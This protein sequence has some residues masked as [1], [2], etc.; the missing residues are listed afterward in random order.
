LRAEPSL[1]VDVFGLA[2]LF[3]P[4]LRGPA[5]FAG[6]GVFARVFSRSPA[7]LF[8]FPRPP[9]EFFAVAFVA[10]FFLLPASID[11]GLRSLIVFFTVPE[12]ARQT[13]ASR[14]GFSRDFVDACGRIVLL[15]NLRCGMVTAGL[16]GVQLC[17]KLSRID[18]F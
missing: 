1:F 8:I 2:E 3:V 4:A 13:A 6:A 15:P 12:D 7:A 16:A 17:G 9:A 5:R 18:G 10:V 14:S 11:T